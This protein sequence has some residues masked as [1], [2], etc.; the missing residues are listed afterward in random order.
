MKNECDIVMDLL[1]SYSDGVLSDTSKEFVEKHLKTCKNCNKILKD[2]NKEDE[3][4]VEKEIDA[5]KGIK[6]KIYRKNIFICMSLFFLLGII[7]FNIMIFINYNKFAS[8]MQIFLED[9]ITEEQLK[10]IEN[11]IKNSTESVE[12]KYIS[13]EKEL[14]DVKKW[15]KSEL[16]GID[17]ENNPMLASIKIEAD[18]KDIQEITNLVQNMP[19][20]RKISTNLSMNPY[21][22]F[23][24]QYLIK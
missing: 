6:K 7:I 4:I 16:I 3:K 15:S 1:F 21:E 22:L 8:E 11:A 13:K 9:N 23:I 17:T 2:I 19:G 14:E 5:F 24:G 20:I 18:K 12:I 10:N